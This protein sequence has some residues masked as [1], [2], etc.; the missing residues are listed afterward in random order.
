MVFN[1][2]HSHAD[3]PMH[4]RMIEYMK[5]VVTKEIVE[6][7]A[8]EG[9]ANVQSDQSTVMALRF[10]ND[11]DL[12]RNVRERLFKA[13]AFTT[14]LLNNHCLKLL[15]YKTFGKVLLKSLKT[16]PDSFIQCVLQLSF[17]RDQSRFT[18]TYETGT[19]RAF[20]H[21]RT[22]TIRSL[23]S[24]SREL[25][26]AMEDRS[27]TDAK[28][29]ALLRKALK[30]HSNYLRKS[31][32]GMGID[33]HLLGLRMTAAGNNI[34]MPSIFTDSSYTLMNTFELSTSSMAVTHYEDYLGF[35][36]PSPTSYGCCYCMTSDCLKM[37][38]SGNSLCTEKNV[39]RF[40]NHIEQ[41]MIDL[42]Q[43]LQSGV[44]KV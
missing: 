30:S 43:V 27:S 40:H 39:N 32:Q 5:Q 36:A 35:G 44:S 24:E 2:E 21:G 11:I 29:Y 31:C 16:S 13:D 19:T 37:V 23:T 25:C 26:L 22:E 20:H 34:P 42:V 7:F 14:T 28:R 9:V 18:S 4:S 8:N 17:Y 1:M 12:G 41:A 3:A 38:I 10:G 33:R 6:E 15:D